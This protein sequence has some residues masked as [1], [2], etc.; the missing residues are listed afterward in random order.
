MDI[1]SPTLNGSSQ[2][3]RLV[4]KPPSH[5]YSRSSSGHDAQSLRSNRS[6][7]SLRRTPSA[8]PARSS[9]APTSASS[10][11]SPRHPPSAQLSNVSPLL[12]QGDFGAPAATSRL[13]YRSGHSPQIDSPSPARHPNHDATD[14][15][16]GAPFD[17]AAILNRLESPKF[18]SPQSP[19][20]H[21]QQQPPQRQHQLHQLHQLQHQ[22]PSPPLARAG[23]NAR[24][25]SPAL[26]SSRSFAV[27]DSSP[28][29]DKNAA[30]RN[31]AQA[32]TPKRYSADSGPGSAGGA[33]GA[34]SSSSTGGLVKPPVVR[35]KSGFSGFV[36]SLV[37]SQKKPMISAPENPIHVTHVGYDSSTGQFTV[38]RPSSPTLL[39]NHLATML[40]PNRVYRKNG[41]DS[42]ARAESPKK[43]AARTHKPWSISFNSTRKQQR[44][45][46]KT[47]FWRSL[48]MLA[49]KKEASIPHL[50]P[51]H[52][53][54]LQCILQTIWVSVFVSPWS[55][56]S[57]IA[58]FGR[59][60][61]ALRILVR[62]LQ[63][64]PRVMACL[65]LRT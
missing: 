22:T 2:R 16:L 37:G 23:P 48:A 33:S 62:P 11:S 20:L 24:V 25:H 45:L 36:N 47:R 6:S 40:T 21:Q 63:F 65:W 8:P 28:A 44:S 61:A 56:L 31:E 42:S 27:M 14:D 18:A 10:T 35:K 64:H 54:H 9:N 60:Q 3:R 59:V 55:C 46:P 53:P 12:A 7:Q 51:R 39:A 30:S 13:P 17:S 1:Q 5:H 26:R 4:K 49:L 15:L 43:N 52:L 19:P 32:A 41:N 38:G 50:L 29:A 58:D 57:A 34:G